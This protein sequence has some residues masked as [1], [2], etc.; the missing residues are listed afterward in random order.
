MNVSISVPQAEVLT[1]HLHTERQ[2]DM[3]VII[4]FTSL[5]LGAFLLM[6]LHSN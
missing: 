3:N 2:K 6:T 1:A 4:L 5:L